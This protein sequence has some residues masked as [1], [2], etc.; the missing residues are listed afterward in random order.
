MYRIIHAE[1]NNSYFLKFCPLTHT[2]YVKFHRK[3]CKIYRYKLL[4]PWRS[5]RKNTKIKYLYY[6]RRRSF[7]LGNISLSITDLNTH[8]IYLNTKNFLRESKNSK[9]VTYHLTMPSNEELLTYFNYKIKTFQILYVIK[10]RLK[11]VSSCGS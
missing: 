8:K 7:Q 5:I 3:Q 6:L 11:I 2:S 1:Q 9:F 4:T 10:S